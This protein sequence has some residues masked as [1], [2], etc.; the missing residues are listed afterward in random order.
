MIFGQFLIEWLLA[1][2]GEVFLFISVTIQVVKQ[3][4][5]VADWMCQ[6]L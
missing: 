4:L 5:S 2:S 6:M 1:S 3:V